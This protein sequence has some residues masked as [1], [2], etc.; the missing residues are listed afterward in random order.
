MEIL[1]EKLVKRIRFAYVSKRLFLYRLVQLRTSDTLMQTSFFVE[2]KSRD[3]VYRFHLTRC[4][5]AIFPKREFESPFEKG[6]ERE[7]VKRYENKKCSSK[8][9]F[10]L[11]ALRS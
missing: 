2:F 5:Y 7:Y 6:H 1:G 8:R 4:N 10:V 9:L 3:S 11:S